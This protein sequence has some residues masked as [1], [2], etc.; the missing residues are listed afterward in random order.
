VHALGRGVDIDR[1]V[2]HAVFA[3]AQR[4]IGVRVQLLRP[5]FGLGMVDELVGEKHEVEQP[6]EARPEIVAARAGKA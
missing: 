1:L 6:G 2:R 4:V 3:Q 5:L